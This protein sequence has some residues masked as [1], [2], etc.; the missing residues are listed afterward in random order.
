MIQIAIDGPGGA[1]KSTISKAIAAKLGIVYVDT[2][3]LYRTVGYYVRSKDVDPHD[4]DGVGALLDEIG[5]EV[6]YVDGSQ[7]VF[8]NGEDLGDKIRTPE[9]S[10]YASAVSAIPSV[11]AFLLETQKDIARKNS[12]IMDGRDIGTVILPNADVKIY[13]TASAECRAKRRYDE[14][15]AKGQTVTYEDVLR[16]MNERDE[17]DS[18]REIAPAQAAQDAVVFDNTGMSLEESVAAIIRLIEEKTAGDDDSDENDPPKEENASGKKKAKKEPRTDS[19][20][21][22][23]IYALFSGIVGRFL[24]RI[25]VVGRQNEPAT[26]GYLVCGNHTSATDAVVIC[27]G[28]RKHQVRLMAKKELFKI[29]VLAPLIRMLGAFPVDRSGNNVSAIKTAVKLLEEGKCMGMFPQGTRHPATDP[30]TTPVKNGAALIATRAHADVV[31]VFIMRKNHTFKLFR[32]T[33]LVIGEPIPF[34]SFGYDPDAN[35]EYARITNIIFDRICALGEEFAKEQEAKKAA[36]K[37]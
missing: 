24:F 7:R 32:R 31:P 20:L 14:L 17:A 16:E 8:L 37:K 1:G 21:Y 27:Y 22:R 9:M 13:L 5:I 36:K 33:Y 35:G 3:A 4:R 34:E 26:G 18:S 19:R 23:V 11:R 15:I 10:M 25:R 6:K 12:V 28:F 29:P 2:G 30:R